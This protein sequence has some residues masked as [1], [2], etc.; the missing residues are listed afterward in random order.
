LTLR[1]LRP[2]DAD[3]LHCAMHGR[4]VMRYFPNAQ[5]PSR[6]RVSAIIAHQLE[7]WRDHGYGWWA[8]EMRDTGAFAGWCGL[9]F[10]AET[11]E[12]EV[13]YMLG[14]EFWGRGLATEAALAAIEFGFDE[15][16]LDE[17]VALVHPE[18]T[19]SRRVIEK[20]GMAFIA[21]AV[22]FGMTVRRYVLTSSGAGAGM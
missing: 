13:A 15:L 2:D 20:L 10:L 11:G 7:H 5:P 9:Q 16:R 22:Y 1:P 21:E 17:I 4:D 12:I 18:N 8:V 19:R 3:A 6:R 14:R